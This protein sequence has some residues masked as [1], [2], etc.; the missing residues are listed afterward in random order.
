MIVYI[1]EEVE[2][3]EGHLILSLW[4][5]LDLAKVEADRLFEG[6]RLPSGKWAT[7]Y[8][9][10]VLAMPLDRREPGYEI[11]YEKLIAPSQRA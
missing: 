7:A 8:G 2:P 6:A 1:V 11:V 3:Y 4:S 9:Y 5:T 10:R